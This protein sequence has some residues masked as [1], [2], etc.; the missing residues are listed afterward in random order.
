MCIILIA[1]GGK[2]I[3]FSDDF[4]GYADHQEEV[5]RA[6]ENALETL[7]AM[8]DLDDDE[9]VTINF[10]LSSRQKKI[11]TDDDLAYIASE[12]RRRF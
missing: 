2:N 7:W 12:I 4:F 1:N 11:F 8:N 9:D 6:I 3:M 5:E 10:H